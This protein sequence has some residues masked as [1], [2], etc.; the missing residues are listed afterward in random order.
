MEAMTFYKSVETPPEWAQK[1][2]GAGRLKGMT[3]INPQW[4]IK[5]LT[6]NFGFCGIGWKYEIKKLWFEDCTPERVVFAEIAL[7]I[8]DKDSNKWSEAIP[9]VG[10]SKMMTKE[11]EGIHI[12]DECYKMAITDS[13]SVACKQLGIG[14]GVYSGSKYIPIIEKE[15]VEKEKAELK[16]RDEND[17]IEFLKEIDTASTRDESIV[18]YQK[19]KHLLGNE[20]FDKKMKEIGK[21]F[22][23][24]QPQTK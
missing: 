8:Y 21:K 13:I 16:A 1:T 5:V 19:Y 18:I 2:I 15:N 11:K 3:D 9:G 7:F 4:R 6:E 20:N 22:P 12:S 17:L 23:A 14:A 10:G 24:P